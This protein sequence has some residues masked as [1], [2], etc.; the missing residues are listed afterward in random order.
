MSCETSKDDNL[1]L[2][3]LLN[4]ALCPRMKYCLLWNI[5]SSLRSRTL[6]FHSKD[7]VTIS[8]FQSTE[9]GYSHQ[10]RARHHQQLHS[11]CVLGKRRIDVQHLTKSTGQSIHNKDRIL[12]QKH[13]TTVMPGI[14]EGEKVWFKCLVVRSAKKIQHYTTQLKSIILKATGKQHYYNQT[15]KN[16]LHFTFKGIVQKKTKIVITCLF[17]NCMNFI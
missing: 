16:V 4:W 13:T 8:G 17:Q 15:M 1:I 9:G 6:S 2:Q 14:N 3:W 10:T 11:V 5:S 12:S 7:Q